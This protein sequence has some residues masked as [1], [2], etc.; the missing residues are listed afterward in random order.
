MLSRYALLFAFAAAL[1]VAQ[2]NTGELNVGVRSQIQGWP[3]ASKAEAARHAEETRK[4]TYGILQVSEIPSVEKLVKPVDALAVAQELER[5]LAA[6]GF[7][8]M[9][10]KTKPDIVITAAYGRGWLPNPYQSET[11]TNLTGDGPP[12]VSIT[13]MSQLIRQKQFNYEEKLQRANYEK[14]Y[15]RVEAWKYPSTPDEKPQRLWTTLM[16]VDDPDHRDFN[17][18]FKEMLSVGAAYFGRGVDE[19]EVETFR[20]LPEGRVDVGTPTV[21][22]PATKKP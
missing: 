6:Q 19:P 15:I 9:K 16:N 3:K 4:L 13:D 17:A 2:E 18:V 20:P 8:K 14:L 22:E 7:V 1:A 11:A 21:V 10:P 5:Q 12:T